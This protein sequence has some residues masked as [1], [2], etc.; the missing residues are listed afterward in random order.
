[1]FVIYM[2]C[3]FYIYNFL[4]LFSK[5]YFWQLIKEEYLVSILVQLYNFSYFSIKNRHF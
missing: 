2:F 4:F 5:L 1:M 3:I